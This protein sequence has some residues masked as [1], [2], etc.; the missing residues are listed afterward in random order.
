MNSHSEPS[1]ADEDGEETTDLFGLQFR[2]DLVGGIE[3]R[4]PVF[5]LLLILVLTLLVLTASTIV[6][7]RMS[8]R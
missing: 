6:A 1:N 7:T 5:T 2:E 8:A 3:E 4:L